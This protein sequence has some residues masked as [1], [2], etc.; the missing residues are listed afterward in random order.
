MT[1]RGAVCTCASGL[2]GLPAEHRGTCQ[3]D[4]TNIRVYFQPITDSPA[5][6]APTTRLPTKIPTSTP[7]AADSPGSD[8]A[9]SNTGED[10][11]DAFEWWWIVIGLLLLF[12]CVLAV[13]FVKKRGKEPEGHGSRAAP[14]FMNMVYEPPTHDVM[15]LDGLE[16]TYATVPEATRGDGLAVNSTYASVATGATPIEPNYASSDRY[17]AY[18]DVAPIPDRELET[19]PGKTSRYTPEP[20]YADTQTWSAAGVE[21]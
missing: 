8:R 13:F 11:D 4:G 14:G 16:H 2:M 17:V 1:P 20:A 3:T 7:T 15:T 10:D 18:T 21:I 5:T 12:A 9:V 6:S 19:S